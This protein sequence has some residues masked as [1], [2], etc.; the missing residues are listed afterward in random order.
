MLPIYEQLEL[1]LAALTRGQMAE[2]QQDRGQIDEALRVWK[3][4]Y[5]RF[6]RRSATCRRSAIRVR[7]LSK[8]IDKKAFYLMQ[9]NIY[10]SIETFLIN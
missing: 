2:I 8:F 3:T 10:L 9:I 1:R 7:K 6:S 4:T 5:C